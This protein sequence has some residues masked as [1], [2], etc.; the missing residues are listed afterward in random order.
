MPFPRVLIGLE[1][2]FARK[3]RFV[4]PVYSFLSIIFL[5]IRSSLC[6]ALYSEARGALDDSRTRHG[7]TPGVGRGS[8]EHVKIFYCCTTYRK[9]V[10]YCASCK[11]CFHCVRLCNLFEGARGVL[12]RLLGLERFSPI[13]QGGF[14][15]ARK[16]VCYKSLRKLCD[17]RLPWPL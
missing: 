10:S 2:Y 7:S 15:R 4:E 5:C 8:P 12:R 3:Y 6:S 11:M 17:C 16:I 14:P 13:G 1:G 9:L